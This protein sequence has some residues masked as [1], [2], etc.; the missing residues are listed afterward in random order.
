MQQVATEKVRSWS[1]SIF[2]RVVAG[3]RVEVNPVKKLTINLSLLEEPESTGNARRDDLR[4]FFA[5][6]FAQKPFDS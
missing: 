6:Y 3:R 4:P 5:R 2:R 1:D